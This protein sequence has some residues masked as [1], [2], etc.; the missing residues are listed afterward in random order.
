MDS[1]SVATYLYPAVTSWQLR[2]RARAASI[3]R[4]RHETEGIKAQATNNPGA[5]SAEEDKR[6]S[7][8]KTRY[9][10]TMSDREKE[11]KE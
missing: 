5:S 1:G 11:C 9:T 4:L 3:M 10:K 7:T 8:E 6:I 2:H